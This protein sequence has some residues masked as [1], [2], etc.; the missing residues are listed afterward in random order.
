MSE[1]TGNDRGRQGRG[2]PKQGPGKRDAAGLA[3][4]LRGM[5]G[6]SYGRYK[7]LT[8][9]WSFEGFTLDVQKVQPDPYAPASRCEVRVDPDTAGFPADLWSNP[10]RARALAGILVRTAYR[11]LKDSKLRVDAGYQQVLDRSSCQV[12]DGTVVLRLG[13]DMHQMLCSTGLINDVNRLI[14][15]LA[16]VDV[17][18]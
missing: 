8:G 4:Q 15:Q 17:T 18:R 9:T 5:H 12:V 10:V 2:G 11:R 6:S 14:R 16:V 1:R 7:S 13:I 3:Q